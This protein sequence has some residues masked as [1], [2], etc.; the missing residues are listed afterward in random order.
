MK[1]QAMPTR[2]RIVVVNMSRWMIFISSTT[3]AG[4][5]V[6]WTLTPLCLRTIWLASLRARFTMGMRVLVSSES[7]VGRTNRY[8]RLYC[9][10]D[11]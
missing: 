5:P 8:N 9:R 2:A 1:M 10:S 7:V 3:R 11:M 6:N 4:Y